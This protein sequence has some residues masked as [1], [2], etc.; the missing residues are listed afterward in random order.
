MDLLSSSLLDKR[1]TFVS[2]EVCDLII[3][4][5]LDSPKTLANCGLV[6]RGW[7]PQSRRY[8]FNEVVCDSHLLGLLQSSQASSPSAI[9]LHIHKLTFDPSCNSL[10]DTLLKS[11]P[12][13]L[14]FPRLVELHLTNTYWT[15]HKL[16]P[17]LQI[18]AS[19]FAKTEHLLFSNVT[20]GSFSDLVQSIHH[21]PSLRSLTCNSVDWEDPSRTWTPTARPR[22]FES[23]R[24]LTCAFT[25][26]EVL[27][28]WFGAD[29]TATDDFPAL[30]SVSLTEVLQSETKAIGAFLLNHAAGLEHLEIGFLGT[31]PRE[32]NGEYLLPLQ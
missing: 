15:A 1:P 8:L 30:S 12:T 13:T 18:F 11:V 2:Q 20:F 4:S 6:C 7:L 21:F 29:S 14:T 25:S 27:L 16:F 19:S 23:L 22:C 31:D 5:I 3:D 26:I 32:N 24:R 28:K 10:D 17:L 9:N